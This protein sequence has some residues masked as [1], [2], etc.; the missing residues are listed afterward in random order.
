[1]LSGKCSDALS[2]QRSTRKTFLLSVVEQGLSG[3]RWREQ[4]VTAKTRNASSDR[5][6]RWVF[7]NEAAVPSGR[8]EP[9]STPRQTLLDRWLLLTASGDWQVSTPHG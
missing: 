7:L 3:G 2:H 6:G 8:R 5:A 1:M 4:E 9:T